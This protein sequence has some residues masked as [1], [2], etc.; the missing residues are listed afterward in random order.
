MRRR[1]VTCPSPPRL[2]SSQQNT[3]EH[4]T[5][6]PSKERPPSLTTAHRQLSPPA[7]KHALPQAQPVQI[8]P[9]RLGH[10]RHRLS[11]GTSNIPSDAIPGMS[12]ANTQRQPYKEGG[13]PDGISAP[14]ASSAPVLVVI[15][16]SPF[17]AA[18]RDIRAIQYPASPDCLSMRVALKR[19]VSQAGPGPFSN[20][21]RLGAAQPSRCRS[22]G[23]SRL[24]SGP[25]VVPPRR[26]PCS[27]SGPCEA[28]FGTHLPCGLFLDMLSGADIQDPRATFPYCCFC[29]FCY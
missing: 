24:D 14:R 13:P 10:T 16:A 2:L 5:A 19:T 4:S 22:C 1:S 21:Y 8:R 9:C 18:P 17:P 27:I 6:Q 11:Q 23:R 7:S 12:T 29:C 25:S 26:S 28:A 20:I 15:A 3:A